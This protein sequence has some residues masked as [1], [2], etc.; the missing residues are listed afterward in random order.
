MHC[1]KI[2]ILALVLVMVVSTISCGCCAGREENKMVMGKNKDAVVRAECIKTRAG[3]TIGFRIEIIN[4]S[5]DKNLVL[6]VRDNISFLFNVRL[7][8]EE[9]LDVSPILPDITKDKRGPTSPKGYRYDVIPPGASRVWFVSVPHQARVDPR[10]F[11]NDNNLHLTPNGKYMAEI[12]V[13]VGYFTQDKKARLTPKYPEFQQLAIT[14]P[15][16]SV[17][18]DSKLFGQDIESIYRECNK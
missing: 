8:N 4:P 17:V 18:V 10:K 13:V 2:F 7:I 16:I 9:G 5:A 11:T 3:L 15:R 1:K 6:V 14:L 12:K